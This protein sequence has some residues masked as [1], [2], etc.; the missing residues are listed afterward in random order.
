MDKK[1]L[2]TIFTT[3]LVLFTLPA[4]L[5]IVMTIDIFGKA[6]GSADGWLSYW[7]GYLGAIVGLAAI[8]VTTQFQI[9]SQ[10][11]L[12][13]E[14]LAAQDRSMIKTHESQKSIQMYSIEESSRMNDKK[15]RDRIYTNFLMD[16]NEALIEILI[17]LNFLNTEHFNLL[18]DYVDYESIRIGEFKNNFLS[19][20]IDP[21]VMNDQEAKNKMQ[22]LDMKIED[23]KEKETE[24]RMK[25]SGASAKLKSKSMYFSNLELEINNYRR[26]ISAV[27][28]EFHNHIKKKDIDLKNFRE[29]IENKS[30]ELHDSTNGALNLCQRNLSRIVNTLI[31]SPY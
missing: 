1:V 29:K 17:E 20:A 31:S 6:L 12:H 3:A 2:G 10:Y 21:K 22:E 5:S 4:I 24:I 9:N 30:T 27:L 13:K 25:I 14:Q 18:R 26:E 28:E 8:A 11:K 15:E 19:E 7:G 16:K 23:I